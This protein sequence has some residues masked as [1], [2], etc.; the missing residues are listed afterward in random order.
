M[1]LQPIYDIAELAWRKN[2]THAVVCP[3]SRCAP[4]TLGLVRH[5]RLQVR[6]FSDE[7]SA[8]FVALGMAQQ[9]KKPVVLV[10]TSG[11]AT[12]NF[13]P[14]IAEAFFQQVPLVVLTADRPT[15]WVGQRDGQT[16]YQ[17]GIYQN[18]VKKSYHLP[19]ETQHP[20]ARWHFFRQLNEAFDLAHQSPP[21]PVHVNIP[22]REPL[23]PAPGETIEYSKDISLARC[24]G[25]SA[26]PNSEA[27]QQWSGA[28]ASFNKI[29]VVAGQISPDAELISQL[30]AFAN[31]YAIPVVGDITSNVHTVRNAILRSDAF[32]M[33]LD[34]EGKTALQPDLLITIGKSTLSK[35]LKV[36]LR[37][38]KATQHW[39]IETGAELTDPFQSIT[40]RIA[41]EPADFFQ[42]LTVQGSQQKKEHYLRLW[43]EHELHVKKTIA[44][45]FGKHL[46]GEFGFVYHLLP[47][48]PKHTALHLANSLSVRYANWIGLSK[49]H[50]LEV[51]CNRGTS[52]IDGCTSTA[53]G[54]CLASAKM[55]TL[56]TG[57]LAFFYDRNAFWH[58]YRLP[59]LR[60]VLLNNHGGTIFGVIDGPAT[61]PEL[62][63]YFITQQHLTARHLATEFNLGYQHISR[64]DNADV[65]QQQLQRFFEP[66]EEARIL[67]VESDASEAITLF[68]QF[69]ESIQL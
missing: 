54:H 9:T 58:N 69:K 41:L 5:P 44:S 59:N 16:I 15:E 65:I 26:K 22:L 34:S 33:G 47:H 21:G 43:A 40:Q 46:G 53:V 32:L 31:K 61:L 39:H 19:E 4:I 23:Y 67:E 30:D 14:A 49:D 37:N 1:H 24:V 50:P 51:F 11:S 36:F 10:C 25:H 12:Y 7:R 35:N 28:L 27:V 63:E 18:H 48:I 29:L 8:G 45:F 13:A 52:G 38:H 2:V 6:T 60:I 68:Q 20:D 55:H 57:D 66:G 62:S 17:Q 3:G 56:I 42:S 64:S